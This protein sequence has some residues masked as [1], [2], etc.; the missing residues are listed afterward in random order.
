MRTAGE[1][2]G[3]AVVVEGAGDRIGR[4]HDVLFDPNT[5]RITAFLVHPGGLFAK[6]QVLPRLFVRSLGKDAILVEQGRVL[7]D[8]TKEPAVD[9]SLH[10]RTLDN[11]PVLDDTGTVI[12]KVDDVVVEEGQLTVTAFVLGTTIVS[13]MLHGK[14][15]IP[16][17][18]IKAIGDDSVIVPAKYE[19]VQA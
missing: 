11:R 19:V 15:R 4:V 12:G 17:A 6:M 5:G 2:S 18:V 1:L 9:S 13:A 10:A 7:E 16:F 3:L 14:P 8:A